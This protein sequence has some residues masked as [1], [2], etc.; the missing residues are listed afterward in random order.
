MFVSP[1]SL[2]PP[3]HQSNV[4]VALSVQQIPLTHL[5]G[6]RTRIL[7]INGTHEIRMCVP[8]VQPQVLFKVFV[9]QK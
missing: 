6:I 5:K 9:K 8:Y 4:T 3:P 1:H 2:P 7:F